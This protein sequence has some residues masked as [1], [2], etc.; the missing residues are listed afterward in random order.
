MSKRPPF[1]VE[2]ISHATMNGHRFHLRL[3]DPTEKNF[4][5]IDGKAPLILN[6]IAAEFVYYLIKAFWEFQQGEGDESAAVIQYVVDKM[7]ERYGQVLALPGRPRVS[8]ERI[9]RDLDTVFLQLM[10]IADGG[11]PVENTSGLLGID[12][13]KWIAPARMDCAPTYRCN[14]ACGKCYRDCGAKQ[15][16]RE[17]STQQWKTILDRLWKIGIPQTV[18]TGGEPLLR[19]DIVELVKAAELFVTGLVTNGTLLAPVAEQLRDASLDYVQVTLESSDAQ[20]HNAM[21]GADFDAFAQTVAGIKACLDLGMFVST[22]T[23]LTQRNYQG[24]LQLLRFAQSIGLKDVSCNTLICSGRGVRAK[25][26]EGL[27]PDVLRGVLEEAVGLARELGLNLQWFSPTCYRHLNPL[28]LGLGAKGCSAA[29]YNM[30]T[31]PDGSVLP[32]QS[33]PDT[34]GNMMTDD[35]PTIWNNPTCVKLRNHGFASA[36]C[37]GCEHN[38]TCGGSCPLDTDEK[39]AES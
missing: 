4:L 28:E 24:F 1:V 21:V 5:W 34:V 3:T 38:D 6:Q 9:R 35:W 13:A 14:L 22:N 27:R 2:G 25:E 15:T 16:T 26:T 7:Y 11:C 20:V 19:E 31:Q 32:C 33:W 8:R 37:S 30:L 17:L 29:A 23:T 12:F 39:G 10:S 36:E 18:F